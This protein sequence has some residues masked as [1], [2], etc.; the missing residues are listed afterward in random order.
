MFIL[1]TLAP[2]AL[3]VLLGWYLRR[4]GMVHQALFKET[5]KLVY[6]VGIPCLLFVKSATAQVA[7]G[8]AFRVFA[9]LATVAA[10]VAALAWLLTRVLRL[11]TGQRGVFVQG[12]FRGNLA[13]VG[14]PVVLYSL[15]GLDAAGPDAEALAVLAIAPLVP[16]YNVL[17]VVFLLTD[18]HPDAEDRP[19]SGGMV[20]EIVRN[21]LVLACVLGLLWSLLGWPLPT[22]LDRTCAGL[23]QMALPLALLGLGANLNVQGLKGNVVI[24]AL[25]A[26]CKLVLGSTVGWFVAGA[27]G[28]PPND[29]LVAILYLGCPTAVVSY[30][31]SEQ[32]GG[33]L[34]L[35]SDIIVLTTL[36][37]L[38]GLALWLW[39]G[40]TFA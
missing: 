2:V 24:A 38:P 39:V 18:T 6:F 10:T 5:N 30:V 20:L 23:G 11:P 4:I 35:S 40:S 27:L 37:A 29:R 33:D 25:A 36:L 31:L 26:A 28:L 3:M 15:E 12:A 14:L 22:A 19:S 9:V 32:L 17:S 21:P 13:F 1:D 34:Q 7:A 16:L 8:A